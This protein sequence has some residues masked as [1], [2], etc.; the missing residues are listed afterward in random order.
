MWTKDLR[1]KSLGY[2]LHPARTP[3]YFPSMLHSSGR[4]HTCLHP[5]HVR[6]CTP[7]THP[8]HNSSLV[9]P[10]LSSPLPMT[11]CTTLP[12]LVYHPDVHTFILICM[13]HHCT[14]THHS[15]CLLAHPCRAMCPCTLDHFLCNPVTRITPGTHRVIIPTLRS[16]M[17]SAQLSSYVTADW[18]QSVSKSLGG[19]GDAPSLPGYSLI[20]QLSP[21]TSPLS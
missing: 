4:L 21:S 18:G 16:I 17:Q 15:I 19:V 5:G 1:I 20:L 14:P 2:A 8:S 12:G 6:I 9:T 10:S 11:S 3:N 7:Y 13:S